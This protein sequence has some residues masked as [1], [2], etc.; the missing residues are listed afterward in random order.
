MSE[1]EKL[2]H[3]HNINYSERYQLNLISK[4]SFNEKTKTHLKI[5]LKQGKLS[6]IKDEKYEV[7]NVDGEYWELKLKI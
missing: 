2:S 4:L 6:D 1:L 7:W 5:L 3:I